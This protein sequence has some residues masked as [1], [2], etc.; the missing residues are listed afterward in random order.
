MYDFL[1]NLLGAGW[2]GNNV[3]NF[4]YGIFWIGMLLLLISILWNIREWILAILYCV[5]CTWMVFAT[6]LV[7]FL[8]TRF[9]ALTI[10]WE[11]WG[12]WIFW[13]SIAIAFCI[14]ARKAIKLL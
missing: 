1:V 8:V 9:S 4:L 12:L 10:Y 2:F 5:L 6:L 14:F 11:M 7:I 3:G 13:G